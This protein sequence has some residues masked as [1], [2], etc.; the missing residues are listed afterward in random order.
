MKSSTTRKF[1][2]LETP[3]YGENVFE[4]GQERVLK[5]VYLLAKVG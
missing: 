1:D 3:F 2:L 5:I 4:C